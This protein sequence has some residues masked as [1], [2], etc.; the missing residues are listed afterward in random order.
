MLRRGEI[1]LITVVPAQA[2]E[3]IKNNEQVIIQLYHDEIDPLVLDYVNVFGRVY[4]DEINRRIL[5][6]VTSEGQ[7]SVSELEQI[8]DTTQV[9]AA[10]LR[11]VLERCAEALAQSVPNQCDSEAARAYLMELDRNVNEV[12]AIIEENTRLEQTIQEALGERPR[13][14]ELDQNLADLNQALED[15][16]ELTEVSQTADDYL[17]SVRTLTELDQELETLKAHL[18]QFL[19]INPRVL[20]SPFRSEANSIAT[21]VPGTTDFYAPAVIVLLLQH[22]ATTFAA[23]SMVR[24]RQLGTMELFY[25]APLTPL[26]TLI[27]KYL[28]YFIFGGVLAATLLILVVIGLG[29]PVLGSWFYV[30]LA[31]AA[32][33]FASMGFGFIISLISKTDIQAVQYSMIVLLT[34][35]FFSGFFLGLETLWA[36]VRII[37]WLLPATYGILLLRDV[38]LRGDGLNLTLLAWFAGMGLILFLAT[39]GL[40]RRTMTQG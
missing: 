35:V 16:N 2:Y 37:S 11:G 30:G 32:L 1:D 15:T 9:S 7:I 33:L 40:L 27:G 13:P 5:R 10:A 17:A 19:Q 18:D 39:W 4:V 31:I 14:A 28:S 21:V 3:I 25:V 6:L 8:L 24:E 20:V 38:M 12:D 23:L 36:P 34:S 22:L 26:E 29:V